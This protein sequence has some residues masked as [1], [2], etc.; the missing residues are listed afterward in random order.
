MKNL[1]LLFALSS[2]FFFLQSCGGG[3]DETVEPVSATDFMPLDI[4]TFWVYEL[5]VGT[6]SEPS[7]DTVTVVDSYADGDDTIY[8]LS[9]ENNFIRSAFIPERLR[10]SDGQL[11]KDTEDGQVLFLTADIA[12]TTTEL[13]TAEVPADLGSIIYRYQPVL[14]SIDTPAGNFD[15]INI[16]GEVVAADTSEEIH[17]LLIDNFFSEGVGLVSAKT[18][19][20]SNAMPVE[21]KLLEFQLP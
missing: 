3:D 2:V 10:L 1:L 14:Q 7:I 5:N 16:E 13:Y 17:G 20:W 9:I 19:F 4:G 21:I 12:V 11:Y 6:F 15:C 18:Y 8:E